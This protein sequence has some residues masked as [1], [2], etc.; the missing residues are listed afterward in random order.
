MI[1][2]DDTAEVQRLIDAAVAAG[3]KVVYL[4]PRIYHVAQT[5]ELKE[6]L[7]NGHERLWWLSPPRKDL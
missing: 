1:D 2:K 4:Q 6:R 3:E 7:L 5:L